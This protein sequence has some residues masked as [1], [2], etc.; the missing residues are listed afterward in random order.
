MLW[1]PFKDSAPPCTCTVVGIGHTWAMAAAPKPMLPPSAFQH[2]ISESGTGEFRYLTEPLI[3]VKGPVPAS[4]SFSCR[5]PDNPAF[6]H[7]QKMYGGWNGYTAEHLQ[8]LAKTLRTWKMFLRWTGAVNFLKSECSI[9]LKRCHECSMLI[10]LQ[11]GYLTRPISPLLWDQRYI[12]ESLTGGIKLTTGMAYGCR[13]G[14]SGYEGWRTSTTN[15]FHSRL[16]HPVRDYE[17]GYK[18]L[19]KGTKPRDFRLRV[20]NKSDSPKPLSIPRGPFKFFRKIP[21]ILAAQG[22]PPVSLTREANEKI[23]IRKVLI[24]L[25]GHL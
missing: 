7:L 19:I 13:T 5:M 16:Y 21:E 1:E 8:V 12:S 6:R 25:F 10:D 11:W 20:F 24:I 15:L 22:A 18:V 9:Y 14:P 23:F 2:L 17:F 3:P 4:A